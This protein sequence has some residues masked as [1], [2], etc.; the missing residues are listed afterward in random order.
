MK[1]KFLLAWLIC[2]GLGLG[3]DAA[4]AIPADREAD[5]LADVVDDS[6]D[7]AAFVTEDTP[8]DPTAT[9]VPEQ[10]QDYETGRVDIWGNPEVMHVDVHTYDNGV[11]EKYFVSSC[12]YLVRPKYD[13]SPSDE[14]ILMDADTFT[15]I[16]Q[17]L[18]ARR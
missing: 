9:P 11:V 2:A 3:L 12:F 8:V 14:S 1:W 16:M 13:G 15:A 10:W 6:G 4:M 7:G 18:G 17:E 5:D